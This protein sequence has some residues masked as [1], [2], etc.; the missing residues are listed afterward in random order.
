[1]GPTSSILLNRKI[2]FEEIQQVDQFLKSITNGDIITTKST[3]DFSVDSSRLL[4]LRTVGS[5]CSF[6]IYFGNILKEL[7]EDEIVEI[8]LLTSLTI[9]SQISIAA[10]C[11]RDGDHNILGELTLEI[12]NLL[13]GLIHYGGDL[14]YYKKGITEELNGAV[15]SIEYND[16][17]AEYQISDVEFLNNW[18]KHPDFRMI[19]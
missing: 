4:K 6:S 1:M 14:N 9:K 17:M 8:E 16:G 5:D 7:S 13:D 12:A 2:G 19:K 15:Y 11:N 3:R 10:G 18:I